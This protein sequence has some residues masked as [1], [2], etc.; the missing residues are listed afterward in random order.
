MNEKDGGCTTETL[1]QQGNAG[2]CSS[3]ENKFLNYRAFM[4]CRI[5]EN[6]HKMLEILC[7]KRIHIHV[8]SQDGVLASAQK[9]AA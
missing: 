6:K 2:F 3:K 1:K 5:G 4:L 8:S 7:S 9:S